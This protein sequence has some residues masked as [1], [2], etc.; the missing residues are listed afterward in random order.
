MKSNANILAYAMQECY[1]GM[2][3]RIAIS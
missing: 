3:C 2:L 1:A